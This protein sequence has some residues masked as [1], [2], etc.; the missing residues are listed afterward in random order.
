MLI[1]S[2]NKQ[3]YSVVSDHGD[4]VALDVNLDEKL[5]EEGLVR[6]IVSKI[7][8]MRKECDFVVTDH[9]L[10]GYK[11]DGKLAKIF[12]D[13]SDEIASGT[14]ADEIK[15]AASGAFAKE[16]EVNGETVTLYLTKA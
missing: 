8:S 5:I 11:T 16:L 13:Y 15:P 12:T 1:S 10:I 3:G 6:E 7:Q 14:L 9:I 4:T 2:K